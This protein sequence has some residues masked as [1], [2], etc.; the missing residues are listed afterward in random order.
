MGRGTY[1]PAD[2]QEN[3]FQEAYT[4]WSI[5]KD[6]VSYDEIWIRVYE[7]CKAMAKKMLKVSLSD[8]VFHDRLMDAVEKVIHYT[9]ENHLNK[10]RQLVPPTRPKRL[11]TYVALPVAGAFFGPKAVKED[12]E[13]SYEFQT[14][15]DNQMAVDI[16]GY[17]IDGI[18]SDYEEVKGI[19][20]RRLMCT[21]D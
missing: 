3:A 8:D 14:S 13:V 1:K 9:T 5:Y 11:I 15:K 6:K 10:K 21:E 16:L 12:T 17:Q 18:M 7:A 20:Q 19:C 2:D 4:H